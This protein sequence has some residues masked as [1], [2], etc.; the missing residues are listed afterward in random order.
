MVVMEEKDPVMYNCGPF[1]SNAEELKI[2]VHEK[3][4]LSLCVRKLQVN[5][6]KDV[7]I[8][9]ISWLN[10]KENKLIKYCVLLW[11]SVAYLSFRI[12]FSMILLEL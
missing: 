8:T 4:H 10:A 7:N 9:L 5:F 1:T 11:K 6:E 12:H 2:Q 3:L